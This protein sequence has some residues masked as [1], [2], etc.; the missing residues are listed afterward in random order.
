V[1][2]TEPLQRCDGCAH[3]D[4]AADKPCR[5]FFRIK[6]YPAGWGRWEKKCSSYATNQTDRR[7]D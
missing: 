6:R 7:K 5:K 4:P 1:K 3:L 2:Q